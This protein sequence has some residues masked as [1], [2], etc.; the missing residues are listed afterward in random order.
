MGTRFEL[1]AHGADPIGLRAG[2]E[3]ALEVIEEQH[4]RFD[5]FDEASLISH[6]R[7]VAPRMVAV[8][9][10]TLA[11][12]RDALSIERASG[13][14]FDV[15]LGGGGLVID[16]SRG[17]IGLRSPE[18]VVDLGGIAKGHALDLA[19][20]RLVGAGISGAF[21]HG[22]TSSGIAIGSA[23]NGEPWRVALGPDRSDPVLCLTDVSYAVSATHRWQDGA[24]EP[25]LLGRHGLPITE[26]RSAAVV[27][28]CGRTADAWATAVAVSGVAC[29]PRGAGWRG[30]IRHSAQPWQAI[31]SRRRRS[32]GP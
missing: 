20:A 2:S 6:L 13:G 16:L 29:L 27:G 23:P 31:D 8:D 11:L 21:V 9:R 14:A 12:F 18:D 5:R 17:Q 19:A 32:L 3:S 15:T 22:G 24:L 25:H 4:R 26:P 28:P 10:D 30:W 1:V 7:R